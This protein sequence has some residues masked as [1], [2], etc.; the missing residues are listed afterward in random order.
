M[1]PG[2]ENHIGAFPSHLRAVASR[3]V[4]HMHR[5]TDHGARDSQSLGAVSFHLGSKHQL[6]S[7]V[8]HGRLDL[9]IV[10]ADQGFKAKF[11]GSRTDRPRHLAA[12]GAK[13]NHFESK[14][15][16]AD[17]SCRQGVTAVAKN[18]HPLTCEVGG[19]NGFRIPGKP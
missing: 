12:V 6:G 16:T 8:G 3:N 19:I 15:L 5:R 1:H 9:E 17:A 13:A 2:V 11:L 4:L 7:G 14:L 10:I 18:E